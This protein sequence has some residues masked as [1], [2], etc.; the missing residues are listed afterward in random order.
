MKTVE[1]CRELTET[2]RSSRITR[3]AGRLCAALRGEEA[4]RS[5][6]SGEDFDALA[7]ARA[8]AQ[9]SALTASWPM[10]EGAKILCWGGRW[11]GRWGRSSCG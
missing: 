11:G 10:A 2:Q 1:N 5:S 8:T 4:R 6:M 9:A 7:R 3:G